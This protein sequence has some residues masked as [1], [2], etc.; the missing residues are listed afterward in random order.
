MEKKFIVYF[1]DSVQI[2]PDDW[3][4]FN[5]MNHF[6]E[7]TTLKEIEAWTLSLRDIKR[8]PQITINKIE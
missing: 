4:V 6:D 5:Q 1:K 8:M 3:K 2:S 7:N